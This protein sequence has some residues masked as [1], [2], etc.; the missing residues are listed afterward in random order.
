MNLINKDQLLGILRA[1]IPALMAYLV[2]RGWISE[3]SAGEVGAA[4]ITLAAAGWSIGVHTDSAKIA[5]VEEMPAI[6]KIVVDALA[7]TGEAAS[8]AAIDKDRPKVATE[9]FAPTS[10]IGRFAK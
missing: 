3:S 9:T 6:K 10:S 5:S 1:V 2:G 8:Q 4:I 7:P